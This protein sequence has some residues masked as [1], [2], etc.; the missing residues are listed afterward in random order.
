MLA[1][2]PLDAPHPNRRDP[3]RHPVWTPRSIAQTASSVAPKSLAPFPSRR[4]A[5]LR[6]LT[7]L[8]DRL[9]P[10]EQCADQTHPLPNQRCNLPRHTREKLPIL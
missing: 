1:A 5:D 3:L 8:F 6:F 7:A 2:Q 4:P 10:S 9:L